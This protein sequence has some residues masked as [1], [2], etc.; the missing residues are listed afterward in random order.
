VLPKIKSQQLKDL[1]LDI[2]FLLESDTSQNKVNVP[3]GGTKLYRQKNRTG[4]RNSGCDTEAHAC[5]S[6]T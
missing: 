6:R 1:Q 5:G 3:E 2:L 4:T